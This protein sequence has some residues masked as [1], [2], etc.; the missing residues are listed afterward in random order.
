MPTDDLR[1]HANVLGELYNINGNELYMELTTFKSSHVNEFLNFPALAKFILTSLPE[2]E[3]PL[4]H[5]FVRIIL[6]LPFATAD[7]ERSFSAMNRVKSPERSRLGTI[8]SELMLLFDITPEEKWSL[9]LVK[10]AKELA[11]IVWKNRK[12]SEM[13][14]ELRRQVKEGYKMMFV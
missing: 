13:S 7:C 1:K 5:F 2:P 11:H 4:L 9:D 6:I 14:A 3:F 8:L 10:L 12:K